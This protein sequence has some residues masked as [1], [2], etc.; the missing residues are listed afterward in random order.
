[1]E[2]VI[3]RVSEMIDEPATD[4]GVFSEEAVSG[5]VHVEDIAELLLKALFSDKPT[6]KVTPSH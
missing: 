5:A 1:M 4:C 2:H 3:V 6:N